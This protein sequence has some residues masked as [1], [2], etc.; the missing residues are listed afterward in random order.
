MLFVFCRN[1]KRR[2]FFRSEF[3]LINF[4]VS[5]CFFKD[6]SNFLPKT[7]ICFK[8]EQTSLRWS[9]IPS[10]G[11]CLACFFLPL[12]TVPRLVCLWLKHEVLTGN[13]SHSVFVFKIRGTRRSNRPHRLW[14]KENNFLIFLS[15]FLVP[16]MDPATFPFANAQ[17]TNHE[18]N[19]WK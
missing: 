10:K 15:P 2:I 8:K 13:K 3:W 12:T 17:F 4:A 5:Y 14:G 16:G 7:S 9:T 19:S 1:T 18:N 6:V 11:R